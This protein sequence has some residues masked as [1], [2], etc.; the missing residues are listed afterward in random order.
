MC[1]CVQMLRPPWKKQDLV[2]ESSNEHRWRWEILVLRLHGHIH[3]SLT[4]QLPR[5][6]TDQHTEAG[7]VLMAPIT[8]VF[9]LILQ[10]QS[11]P[12]CS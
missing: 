2:C 10:Q 4:S 8:V 1:L 12:M 6:S 11:G 7:L 9:F 5:Q 3:G